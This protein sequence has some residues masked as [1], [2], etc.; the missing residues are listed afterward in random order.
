MTKI[1]HSSEQDVIDGQAV[2][3]KKILSVYDLYVLG[4]SNHLIWRCPTKALRRLYNQSLSDRHLDVGVG[5]DYFLDRCHFPAPTPYV[6][7]VDLNK[8]SLDA[9]AL[10]IRRYQPSTFVRNILEPIELPET[11]FRSIAINYLLHC[12]PGS[13]SEKAVVFDHLLPHL[14]DGCVLFGS[15]ILHK[16][17]RRGFLAKKL[18]ATYNNKGIFH[19]TKDSLEDLEQALSSRF[20]R[21]DIEVKGVVAI[22]KAWK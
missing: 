19:N 17:V 3:S 4:L 7:L 2:Y 12:I 13:I 20:S 14:Q 11:H 8:N 21:Y 15:T 16:G 18:M 5:T 1:R 9:T 10:R 6:A 22:F